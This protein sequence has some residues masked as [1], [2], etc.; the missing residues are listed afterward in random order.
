CYRTFPL[1]GLFKAAVHTIDHRALCAKN[2][3][4]LLY[5]LNCLT[6]H[7]EQVSRMLLNG[8]PKKQSPL[9]IASSL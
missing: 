2:S 8:K 1:T 7:K 3:K 9:L 6:G 4:F 5:S